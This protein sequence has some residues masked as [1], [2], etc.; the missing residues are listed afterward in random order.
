MGLNLEQRPHSGPVW[1]QANETKALLLLMLYFQWPAGEGQYPNWL[2]L[3]SKVQEDIVVWKILKFT[4]A[5]PRYT[6]AVCSMP[7]K[8]QPALMILPALSYPSRLFLCILLGNITQAVLSL[9]PLLNEVLKAERLFSKLF[10]SNQGHHIR[11]WVGF[12]ELGCHI[13]NNN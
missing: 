7:A 5:C 11:A 1:G 10:L 6:P 4:P 2:S 3:V 13:D 8:T 9:C 12:P